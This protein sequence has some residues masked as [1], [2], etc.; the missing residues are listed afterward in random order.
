MLQSLLDC[1]TQARNKR[2][3][4]FDQRTAATAINCSCRHFP[5]LFLSG[6]ATAHPPRS[7]RGMQR[8]ATWGIV[9]IIPNECLQT[10]RFA[11]TGFTVAVGVGRGLRRHRGRRTRASPSP[12]TSRTGVTTMMR[13]PQHERVILPLGAFRFSGYVP[14]GNAHPGRRSRYQPLPGSGPRS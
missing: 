5:P 2:T 3:V 13:A 6:R 9:G 12:R 1:G 7:T 8:G 11:S 14:I 4:K 10:P